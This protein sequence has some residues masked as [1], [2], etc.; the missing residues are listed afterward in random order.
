MWSWN[1]ILEIPLIVNIAKL[2][3][4]NITVLTILVNIVSII[5]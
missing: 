5:Q 1:K 4:E 3:G 2:T